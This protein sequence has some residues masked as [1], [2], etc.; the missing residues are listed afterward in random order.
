MS[1]ILAIARAIPGTVLRV[2]SPYDPGMTE[3]RIAL[4]GP[5]N[6]RDLGGYPTADGHETQ[7]GR[8][9]RSDSMHT[10]TADDVPV[11]RD[12]G[13]RTAIDF[14][15]DDEIDRMG[16]GP[17]G[18]VEIGHVHCP[19]FDGT[20]RTE[21]DLLTGRS[22]ADFYA[23]MMETGAPAYVAAATSLAAD[24]ALPAV[25]F[26][27]AGKDRTGV[28][29]AVVLGLLGVPD[30]V[31][32]ADYVLTHEILPVLTERRIARD[33]SDTEAVRWVNVPD[34]LKGAHAHV[35]EELVTRVR[36]RWGGWLGYASAVGIPDP[37]VASLRAHLLTP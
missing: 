6:F 4:A 33:G 32:V 21:A 8:L 7:W 5:C 36:D 27:M 22:A 17:L 28:F 2:P 1:G 26:C 13:V 30:D 35:M 34:D 12:L 37:A 20:R 23:L 15:S 11:L 18:E 14:R 10:L 19:T 31:I 9:Y 29:A 24:A 16:I 25:F 3:R